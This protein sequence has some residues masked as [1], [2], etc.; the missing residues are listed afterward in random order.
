M[1]V[2]GAA[3]GGSQQ[4]PKTGWITGGQGVPDYN[5]DV[6]NQAYKLTIR[7]V[8]YNKDT[9]T[10]MVW[11]DWNVD[12][13]QDSSYRVPNNCSAEGFDTT[14]ASSAPLV[15]LF[16]RPVACSCAQLTANG[17]CGCSHRKLANA[18]T[19]WICMHARV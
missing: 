8:P 15:R 11:S 19:A 1:L 3:A 9:A 2:A 4:D 17:A 12:K 16:S 14:P 13:L 18:L 6:W 5:Q 10:W 7:N